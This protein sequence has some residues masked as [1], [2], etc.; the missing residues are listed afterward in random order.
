MQ[1]IDSGLF[2]LTHEEL[3]QAGGGVAPLALV[4]AA[5]TTPGFIKFSTAVSLIALGM[6]VA[7]DLIEST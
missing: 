4:A 3:A 6:E 2:E 5:V 7:T 1:T